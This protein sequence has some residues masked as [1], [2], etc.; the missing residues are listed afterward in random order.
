MGAE[1]V[2]GDDARGLETEIFAYHGG[3]FMTVIGFVP[4]IYFAAILGR[5]RRMG[6]TASTSK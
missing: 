6:T 3:M 4:M 5:R 1:R 2:R